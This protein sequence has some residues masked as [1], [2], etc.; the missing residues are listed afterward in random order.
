MVK[1]N[2]YEYSPSEKSIYASLLN[3]ILNVCTQNQNKSE[4]MR[5]IQ[6][7]ISI[8]VCFLSLRYGFQ[9]S[10]LCYK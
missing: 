5:K 10:L 6:F 1:V 3:V 4:I 2:H 8:S 9:A 7:S